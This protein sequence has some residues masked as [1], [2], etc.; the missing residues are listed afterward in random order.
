MTL[1]SAIGRNARASRFRSDQTTPATQMGVRAGP[2][3]R[4]WATQYVARLCPACPCSAWNTSSCGQPWAA[5]QPTLGAA[6]ATASSSPST[7]YRLRSSGRTPGSRKLVMP[8]PAVRA[9]TRKPMFHLASNPIPAQAPAAS[10]QRGSRPA[11]R[12]TTRYSVTAQ[13]RKSGVVVVSSCS[14]PRYSPHVAVARAARTWPVRFAPSWR[15]I[16]AVST[17]SAA[18]TSAGRIRKP[19]SV[20]P[21]AAAVTRASSGVSGGWST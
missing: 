11:S 12:R 9:R 20:L 7:R 5:C 2:V 14:A 21:V 16:A 8:N 13:N 10:H 4:I 19:A 18:R 15:L 17:T 6:I 3:Y 1:A